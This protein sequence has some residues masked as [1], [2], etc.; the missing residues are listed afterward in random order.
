MQEAS[1]LM[2]PFYFSCK[3]I[4]KLLNT[5]LATVIY[6]VVSPNQAGFLKDRFHPRNYNA[7]SRACSQCQKPNANG[8]VI[9]KFDMAKAFDRVT[10]NYL[11]QAVRQF[12]LSEE[13]TNMIWR[14]ISNNWYTININGGRHGFFQIREKKVIYFAAW[15]PKFQQGCRRGMPRCYHMVVEQ[16]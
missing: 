6:K 12:R 5:R 15:Y 10:W 14:L 16:F 7:H 1:D 8:N 2:V 13:W 4:S 3:I 11:C 9:M